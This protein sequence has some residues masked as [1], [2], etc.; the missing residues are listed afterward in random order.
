MC[1]AT[2]RFDGAVFGDQHTTLSRRARERRRGLHG[3]CVGDVLFRH[4]RHPQQH[5]EPERAAL[6]GH[7]V[8]P[9]LAV[10]QLA[11]SAGTATTRVR[12]R[13]TI[14]CSRHFARTVRTAARDERP[15]YRYPCRARRTA[16]RRPRLRC[17]RARRRRRSCPT[18]VNFIA[19]LIKWTSTW[20]RRGASP[21]SVSGTS[22]VRDH[23]SAMPRRLALVANG[24]GGVEQQLL[25]VELG[26]DQRQLALGDP[27]EVEDVANDVVERLARSLDPV[28]HFAL[29]RG[30]ARLGARAART[31]GWR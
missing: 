4:G 20:R 26:L 5:R 16:G 17:T 14:R 12:C 6:S 19:L 25:G 18:S 9:D 22:F 21:T 23:S 8:D 24:F 3:Q 1:S 27:R 30:R 29:F 31:R 11:E 28:E 7:R 13:A 10:H 2:R 15:R